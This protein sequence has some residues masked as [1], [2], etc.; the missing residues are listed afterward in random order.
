VDAKLQKVFEDTECYSGCT[1]RASVS[2]YAF[3][4]E[5]GKGVGIGLNNIQVVSKGPRLDNHADA[6]QDFKEFQDAPA[7]G[8]G[9]LL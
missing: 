6:E 3:D 4:K 7:T 9:D 8:A 2:V 1:F 5:G